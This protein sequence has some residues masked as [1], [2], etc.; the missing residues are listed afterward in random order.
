MSLQSAMSMFH[1]ATLEEA[2]VRA[3]EDEA[4]HLI[5]HMRRSQEQS[6]QPQ[7]RQRLRGRGQDQQGGL[8][9]CTDD[10]VAVHVVQ[11]QPA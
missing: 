2:L 7:S 1:F 6:T 4:A 3:L 11:T 10:V 5:H 9:R 8:Q